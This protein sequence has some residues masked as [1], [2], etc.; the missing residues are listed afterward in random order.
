ME[1]DYRIKPSNKRQKASMNE[2]STRSESIVI[3][4]DILYA[5]F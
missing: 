5:Y 4:P 1:Q 3:T 2:T